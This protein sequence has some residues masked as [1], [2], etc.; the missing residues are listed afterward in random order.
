MTKHWIAV[1]SYNH[2]RRGMLEG[3]CQVC[4]GKPGPLKLMS[5]GDWLVYYCPTE[6]FGKKLPYRKFTAI[7]KVQIKEPYLFQMSPDFTPWRRDVVY[8]PA[9]PASI[10]PLID[11]LSFIKDKS[12]WGFPFRRGCFTIPTPDFQLIADAMGIIYD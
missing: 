12:K 6:E 4:H 9:H 8:L 7:G 11:R 1:A 2:V 10:E 5:P 3:F